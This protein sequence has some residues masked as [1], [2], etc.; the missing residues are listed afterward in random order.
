MDHGADGPVEVTCI[1]GQPMMA[2]ADELSATCP[3]CGREVLVAATILVGCLFGCW[4]A[5]GVV[6][7]IPACCPNP[8]CRTPFTPDN[9]V[10]RRS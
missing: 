10:E 4:R 1:C 3:T 5:V 9:I 2:M 6:D 8:A 7:N